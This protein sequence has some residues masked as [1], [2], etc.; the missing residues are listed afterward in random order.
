METGPNGS[1]IKIHALIEKV[2]NTL[3]CGRRLCHL[4]DSFQ[5]PCKTLLV[6]TP[7]LGIPP[8]P[9]PITSPPNFS[10]P[11]FPGPALACKVQTLQ[12]PMQL[13][14]Y[15]SA[16]EVWTSARKFMRCV[17][18]FMCWPILSFCGKDVPS[19]TFVTLGSQHNSPVPAK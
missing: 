10:S 13:T 14:P 11:A 9:F 4:Q 1:T 8:H 7:L 12:R 16:V 15:T 2:V 5:C 3:V 6:H 18:A 17:H 19:H